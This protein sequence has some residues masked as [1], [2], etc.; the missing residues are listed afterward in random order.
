M[1]I[2]KNI[3]S[4][5]YKLSRSI[6]FS[7]LRLVKIVRI[8]TQH[9]EIEEQIEV[10]VVNTKGKNIPGPYEPHRVITNLIGYTV[11]CMAGI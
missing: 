1:F 6:S 4:I 7:Y 3:Q 11:H 8:H 10:Y 9:T 2:I 5:L